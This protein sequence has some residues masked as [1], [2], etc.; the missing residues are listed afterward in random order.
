MIFIELEQ[1]EAEVVRLTEDQAAREL[2]LSVKHE[3]IAD[4]GQ[5]EYDYLLFLSSINLLQFED[6]FDYGIYR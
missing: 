2:L 3:Y 5:P 1:F 6:L 4:V